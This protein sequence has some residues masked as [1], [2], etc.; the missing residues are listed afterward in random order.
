MPSMPR[1]H[2]VLLVLLLPGLGC[3]SEG[4]PVDDDTTTDDDDAT[5]DDDDTTTDD[6]DATPDDDDATTDDDDATTDDDDSGDDDDSAVV[7][8]SSVLLPVEVIP[9]DP[10]AFDPVNDEDFF[11]ASREWTFTAADLVGLSNSPQLYVRG[12]ALGYRDGHVDA[13]GDLQKGGKASVRLN[14]EGCPWVALENNAPGVEL[15]DADRL[16]DGIGGG[17]R[18]VRLTV[19]AS[20]LGGINCIL[21]GVNTIEFRFNGT[22]GTSSGYRVV[23]FHFVNGAGDVF[24]GPFEQE[25]PSTWGPPSNASS[26]SDVVAGE[27]L[28]RER[29]SLV[30]TPAAAAP[31][32]VAACADCHTQDG[33]DLEYFAYSNGSIV[34][35]SIFHGLTE[36]EGEQ[37]AAFVRARAADGVPRHGRPWNPPFQPGVVEASDGSL[38]GLDSLGPELWAAGAGLDG[39]LDDELALGGEMIDRVLP[40]ADGDGVRSRSE[41]ADWIRGDGQPQ[42][43]LNLREVPIAIQFPDWNSWL[44]EVHPLDLW[45]EGYW[46]GDWNGL[47]EFDTQT[48]FEVGASPTAMAGGDF[49]G[50]GAP[51]LAVTNSGD[52]T[53][54]I[55]LAQT[56]GPTD[57]AA[58]VSYPV[59]TAPSAILAQDVSA[60]GVV[61]LLVANEGS[62]D[63]SLL[64][65]LGDG[66]FAAQTTLAAGDAPRALLLLPLNGDGFPDL[67]VLNSGDGTVSV[68]ILTGPAAFSPAWTSGVVGSEPAAM[69]A[70]GDVDGDGDEDIAVANEGSDDVR[71]L[72][73][74]G[75]GT[76]TV[77][78]AGLAAGTG[79]T[80][81]AAGDVDDDG[82]TDLVVANGGSD[83]VSVFLSDGAGGFSLAATVAVGSAPGALLLGLLDP[84]EQMDVAV[85]NGGSNNVQVLAGGGDGSFVS[86]ST[87]A[88]GLT[89]TGL[90]HVPLASAPRA[91]LVTVNSGGDSVSTMHTTAVDVSAAYDQA[92]ADVIA[93]ASGAPNTSPA[94][95]PAVFELFEN[96]T[97]TFVGVGQYEI[98][99]SGLFGGWRGH[100]GLTLDYATRR[101]YSHELVKKSLAQWMSVK[102]FE[103]VH[104]FDLLTH[105]PEAHGAYGE[106]HSWP[107]GGSQS[108]HPIAPHITSVN[109][110]NFVPEYALAF[111][112]CAEEPTPECVDPL[113]A[114][115]TR[116]KADYDSS[117][118]YYLQMVLH[119]G[120]RNLDNPLAASP[121]DVGYMYKHLYE[122]HKEVEDDGSVL[123]FGEEP[124]WE[125]LRY[126]AA[127]MKIYQMRDNGNGPAL[128]GWSLRDVHPR[129]LVSNFTGDATKT[130]HLER[131]DEYEP[132]LRLAVTEAFLEV[133]LEVVDYG[134][135]ATSPFHP[136]S[137]SRRDPGPD[138]T[139]QN[140]WW[141]LDPP[142]HVA[143]LTNSMTAGLGLDPVDFPAGVFV[144]LPKEFGIEPLS[145]G[146]DSHRLVPFLVDLG[147]D[148]LLVDG[149]ID[150][151]R[152][153]WPAVDNAWVEDWYSTA[154]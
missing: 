32:L 141:K 40:D 72:L 147:V 50:D 123:L 143:T 55:L 135:D 92:R 73:G 59:G 61:D 101:G 108:V 142:D 97:K 81:L 38:V 27:V 111:D 145:H 98:V 21:S 105:G 53:V 78:A 58:A 104:E 119:A 49:D 93:I 39:V 124:H 146:D 117:V 29:N 42:E 34:S 14:G 13:A 1:L 2:A 83:D 132:D 68:M 52:D 24:G 57:F 107:I 20:V 133:F 11:V 66:T 94:D 22:D 106:L 130:E 75:D 134:S 15:F 25:D 16:Y 51:D 136:D 30:A 63:V 149:L 139:D 80:A 122:M 6:D 137:W 120:A 76:L 9:L 62:D 99:N 151:A 89:P 10:V 128:S 127:M 65:G 114:W 48:E 148:P 116:I 95:L 19:D 115:Q 82:D 86:V 33:R 60:D 91:Q 152:A 103:L 118:W 90:V 23:D 154:P 79:P 150:W 125:S 8:A 71:V 126:V 140:S 112:A 18:T 56:P 153:Q 64:L 4:P 110:N 5:P 144:D 109:N 129:L 77:P 3:P 67:A 74:E 70:L 28:W 36:A 88:S 87:L 35:R 96:I 46:Q 31:A 54:S 113:H 131:L 7:P 41:I 138:E 45:G 84:G 47:G 121:F 102:M 17:F 85:A 100:R 12:H 37:I 26:P 44:P 69:V 43:T